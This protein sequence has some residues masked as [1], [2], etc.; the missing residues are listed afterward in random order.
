MQF[1]MKQ[2]FKMRQQSICLRSISLD[3]IYL[4]RVRSVFCVV[5]LINI[6]LTGCQSANS[7]SVPLGDT[8]RQVETIYGFNVLSNQ[9]VSVD[10]KSNGCTLPRDFVLEKVKENQYQVIRIRRDPCRRRSFVK[11]VEFV[12]EQSFTEEKEVQIINPVMPKFLE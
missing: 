2:K 8:F 11:T 5:V 9:K 12:P 6:L 1:K 3:S 7:E 4:G 10:I